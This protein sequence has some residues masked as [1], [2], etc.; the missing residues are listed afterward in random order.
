VSAETGAG[1]ALPARRLG[2]NR[3]CRV[4][5]SP[6]LMATRGRAGSF[7]RILIA[8]TD[9]PLTSSIITADRAT[10]VNSREVPARAG[11]RC[12]IRAPTIPL[13]AGPERTTQRY[14]NVKKERSIRGT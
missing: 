2:L 13:A 4:V 5:R 8:P 7:S 11:H 9:E 12:F 6:S 14:K 10:V 3:G 1:G